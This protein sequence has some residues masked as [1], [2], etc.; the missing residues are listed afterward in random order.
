MLTLLTR[1][2]F[3]TR[4]RA[5]GI[6]F[7]AGIGKVGSLISP[8]VSEVCRYLN[9]LVDVTSRIEISMNNSHNQMH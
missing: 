6:G 3:P 7:C 5:L 1:Q 2:V 9:V 8:F 4:T